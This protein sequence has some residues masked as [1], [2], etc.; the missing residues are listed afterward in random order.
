MSSPQKTERTRFESKTIEVDEKVSQNK[1][2]DKRIVTALPPKSNGVQ[3]RNTTSP[4]KTARRRFESKT[5]EV[6]EK[7]PETR[8]VK[9]EQSQHS[10]QSRTEYKNEIRPLL[11]NPKAEG[12]R[13]KP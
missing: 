2:G 8:K 13:V 11:K 3:K 1:E 5:I 12:L 10:R 9:K 4:Q 7:C 6:D